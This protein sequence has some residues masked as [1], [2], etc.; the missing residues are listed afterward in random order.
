MAS[1]VD[2]LGILPGSPSLGASICRLPHSGSSVAA[3]S[4]T[5]FSSTS[6]KIRLAIGLQDGEVSRG[7]CP[8]L[9]IALFLICDDLWGGERRRISNWMVKLSGEKDGRD[10]SVHRSNAESALEEGPARPH[11]Q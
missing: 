11:L 3:G 8:P 7:R 9:L 6:Y 10:E 2:L 5:E 4:T 1:T